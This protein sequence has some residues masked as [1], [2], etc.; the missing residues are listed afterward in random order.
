M[1][2]LRLVVLLAL[3]VAGGAL[4]QVPSPYAIDIPAWFA[5][6]FLDF[7]EDVGDAAR[8][9]KRLLVYFGQDGC[10][11][12]ALLMANNFSQPAIVDKT[13][14][15]FVATAINIWGDREI[16]W[17]DG[18][19]MT[20]KELARVLD[21]QFTP[22][23]LI[24]DEAANVAVRIDGYYP[25]RRFDAVLDYAAGRLERGQTLAEYLQRGV[26]EAAASPKL[27][28]EPFFMRAPLDLRRRPGGKPL[29]VLFETT[30]CAAC[31][32]L[33]RDA[34]QRDA[35]LAQVRRFDV[36]RLA[37]IAPTPLIRP[38]GKST[39]AREWARELGVAYT[40]TV[41]FFGV[42][43]AEVFRIGAYLRPFHF[44]SSFAYVAD[45]AYRREPSFQ[46]FLQAR[47]A[48]MR[49]RGER[50]ELLE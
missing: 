1:G 39:T 2:K 41:V 16:T 27:H 15:H 14:R 25:P 38:D 17:T 40:P 11:Y 19:T 44:A 29:A 31:D 32:E 49:A 28:D 13:R 18:R 34:L 37:L 23:I 30:D 3:A 4:A 21:V 20:E 48:E 6:T 8:D 22:T 33:H 42:D 9:G 26:K 35:V 45:G 36:A 7:R 24:F 12:C 50:V 5:T 10:P 46:R 47:A 43:G